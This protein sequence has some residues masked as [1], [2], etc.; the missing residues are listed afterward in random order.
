MESLKGRGA[1]PSQATAA[2]CFGGVLEE[3]KAKSQSELT[4]PTAEFRD[5]RTAR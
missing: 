5:G 2:K 1:P 3:L 4:E